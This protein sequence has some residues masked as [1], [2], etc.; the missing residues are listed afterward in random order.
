MAELNTIARPYAQAVFQLAE[1]KKDLAK[2][3]DVLAT[4]SVIAND[5]GVKALAGD[6]AVDKGKL[7]ALIGDLCGDIA[8][9]EVKSLIALLID[10]R[11]F[12]VL[13]EIAQLYELYRAESE[14]TIQVD[15]ISAYALNAK[16]KDSIVAAMTK[17]LGREVKLV[18]TTDKSL[19]GG[20]II[21]AGDLVIDGSVVKQMNRLGSTLSR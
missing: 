9:D 7:R 5:E 1:G 8:T 4:L 21:R 18:A 16:Q 2:W 17:R 20:A 6:P 13:P 3:S 12:S 14:K 19:V 15:V 10:N 11:R